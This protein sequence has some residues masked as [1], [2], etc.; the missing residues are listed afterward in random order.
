MSGE[1]KPRELITCM[2]RMSL[3]HLQRTS[4]DLDGV[5]RAVA[6]EHHGINAEAVGEAWRRAQ[7]GEKFPRNLLAYEATSSLDQWK[8]YHWET[9][10]EA[11]QL[12]NQE[13]EAIGLKPL[14]KILHWSYKLACRVSQEINFE[15][16]FSL[17]IHTM[18]HL[19]E[20]GF[21]VPEMMLAMARELRG[22]SMDVVEDAWTKARV[23]AE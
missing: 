23:V 13:I 8:P 14:Q 5:M 20:H 16:C 12:L 17:L 11:L 19:S 4:Y 7:L 21:S 18:R 6:M 10:D 9:D 22:E 2:V 15:P 1:T 3:D